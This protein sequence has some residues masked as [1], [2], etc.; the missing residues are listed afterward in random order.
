MNDLLISKLF[1]VLPQPIL[2]HCLKTNS[3]LVLSNM[4]G[5]NKVYFEQ[6][7]IEDIMFWVPNRFLIGIGFSLLT[8][9]GRF[10]LGLIVDKSIID[11]E[12][13]VNHILDDVFRNLDNM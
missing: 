3:T 6:G 11:S 5:T 2:K 9:G 12:E 10:Q 13:E 1:G 4:P 7:A 8:Y